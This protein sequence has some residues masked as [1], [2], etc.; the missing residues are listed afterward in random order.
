MDAGICSVAR[1][2]PANVSIGSHNVYYVKCPVMVNKFISHIHV[3]INLQVLR[4]YNMNPVLT[5]DP[6]YP[7][8]CPTAKATLD[9]AVKS[10]L[11][12]L[13]KASHFVL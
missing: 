8:I 3:A 11:L 2:V 5:W 6:K 10:Q 7:F 9:L 1:L 4:P 13:P 12:K